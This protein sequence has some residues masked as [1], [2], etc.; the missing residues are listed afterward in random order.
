MRADLE[1]GH[2]LALLSSFV[3]E[4]QDLRHECAVAFS[5]LLTVLHVVQNGACFR[6][7]LVD[8][9]VELTGDGVALLLSCGALLALLLLSLFRELLGQPHLRGA[10]VVEVTALL[11]PE[12]LKF[13]AFQC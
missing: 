11:L 10:A 2:V 6:F 13:L 9:H 12:I 3:V 8:V 4:L 7:H 1:V 5:E